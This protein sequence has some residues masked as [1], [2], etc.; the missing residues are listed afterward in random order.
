MSPAKHLMTHAVASFRLWVLGLPIWTWVLGVYTA[1]RIWG[2]AA[3][4][5]VGRQQQASPWGAGPLSYLQFIGIWDSDWYRHIAEIGYPSVLPV[6]MSG[7]V[8]QNPWAFYPLFPMTTSVLMK[9]TGLSWPAA[10]GLV[11]IACGAVASILLYGLFTSA[12]AV[13]T[14]TEDVGG[15]QYVSP[16]RILHGL[17]LKQPGHGI[18][19]FALWTTALVLLSPVAPIL[20][21]PYAESMNFMFLAGFLLALVRGNLVICSIVLIP[22]CL[23][24]PVGVPIALAMGCWWL[25]RFVIAYRGQIE[26]TGRRRFVVAFGASARY[27]A[28]GLFA[29][30]CALAWPAIAWIATG[31]YDAYTATETAWRGE[32]LL[33]FQPWIDQALNYLGEP[34][35]LVLLML[36][37]GFLWVMHSRAVLTTL[38]RNIRYWCYAYVAYLLVFLFPQ[39]STFRLLLPV[40]PLAAPLVAVSDSRAYRTTLLVGAALGQL[41]WIGWLWHWKELPSGGDYPP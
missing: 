40:F 2:W 1:T 5:L 25:T 10:G 27:L 28:V 31:R 37:V 34:G 29:C 30:V 6:D 23:S 20:Q 13:A 8:D 11:S 14:R 18:D 21:V 36:V 33:P 12:R 4:T 41:I 39:S 17:G 32:H 24:R 19:G 38:P 35:P 9:V 16:R 26:A 15:E 22:T 3:F 7:T